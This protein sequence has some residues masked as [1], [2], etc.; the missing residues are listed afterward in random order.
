[1]DV[2]VVI[3]SGESATLTGT[4]NIG[5]ITWYDSPSSTTPIFTGA[6]FNTGNLN[7]TTQYYALSNYLGCISDRERTE[8]IVKPLP[9][10][11]VIVAVD[12]IC[13]GNAWDANI[14]NINGLGIY[15]WTLPDN[16]E[17]VT[18]NLSLTPNQ[19]GIYKVKVEVDGCES[20]LASKFVHVILID[21]ANFNY[22]KATYC[23]TEGTS[24]PIITG[25]LGGTFTQQT[26][27]GLLRIN[28]STG[29]ITFANSKSGTH[30]IHYQTFGFCPASSTQQVIID[31]INEAYFAYNDPY[32]QIGP[33]TQ[34]IYPKASILG[35]SVAGVF[36]ANNAGLNF[37]NTST[38]EIDLSS[39]QPG[40][41][42]VTNSVTSVNACPDAAYSKT[43][44]ILRKPN[45]PS[46]Q[47]TSPICEGESFTLSVPDDFGGS[48]H[49]NGPD[50]FVR[51]GKTTLVTNAQIGVHDVA[52]YTAYVKLGI[53]LSE[54]KAAKP[55]KI[56]ALPTALFNYVLSN[57]E[58]NEVNVGDT[59]I[60]K[61]QSSVGNTYT[62]KYGDGSD[63]VELTT[64][65]DVQH[66][67]LEPGD[68]LARL[69][70]ESPVKCLN[71]STLVIPVNSKLN[72][73]NAFSP[74]GDGVNDE[75][76]FRL[77]NIRTV[78]VK[79]F[80]RWGEMLYEGSGSNP[81]WDGLRNGTPVLSGVYVYRYTAIGLDDKE[82]SGFGTVTVV[83]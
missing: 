36:S 31:T 74:N 63:E 48:V 14:Q 7:D 56:D 6:S 5:T 20:G 53:C 57:V 49:W 37:S 73:G 33:N 71:T 65:S 66:I 3:C 60:L 62:W 35:T 17:L 75:F 42:T 39:S 13:N 26:G 28:P 23:V 34:A 24:L 15:T 81:T 50:G 12:S 11:P 52:T 38:G 4:S 47:V 67:Y 72:V 22:S 27:P 16:S 1:M 54:A 64:L 69:T 25:K 51:T 9:A 76:E 40:N 8:V 46:P 2:I 10:T 21:D 32:C 55:L 79:V 78:T 45:D 43:V 41:Y 30:T 59:V 68:Y 18:S 19:S 58:D 77:D 70:V 82:Y 83:P 80:N 44:T 61:N 29:L